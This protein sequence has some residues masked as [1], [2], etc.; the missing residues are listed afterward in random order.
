M[1]ERSLTSDSALPAAPA[2]HLRAFLIVL[3]L[4]ILHAWAVWGYTGIFWGEHGR[5]LH[6]VARFAAGEVP[7]RDFSYSNPPLA[8][9]LVGG[10]ARMT[11]ATYAGITAITTTLYLLT[12]V[13]YVLCVRR[14]VPD[15]VLPVTLPA[16]LF[17]VSYSFRHGVSLPAGTDSPA[18]P[19]GFLCILGAAWLLLEAVE[20]PSLARAAGYGLLLGLAALSRHEFWI[21]CLYLLLAGGAF[22]ARRRAPLRVQIA[23]PATFALIIV[24]GAMAAAAAAGWLDAARGFLNLDGA[25]TSLLRG[26][27]SI[28]R[29]VAE[30]AGAAAMALTAITALWLC[31]AVNDRT[32]SRW[33]GAMLLLFLTAAAMHLGTSVSIAAQL[34]ES[35]LPDLPTL[36]QDALWRELQRG[37]GTVSAALA[38]FDA[39]LQAHL[40]PVILPPIILVALLARWKQWHD[41]VLRGRVALLLGLCITARLRRGF[42]GADWYNVL[43]ELPAYAV[44][45]QL[46]CGPAR[47]KAARAVRAGLAVLIVIGIY[48]YVSLAV[49]PFTLQGVYPQMLT[50]N[51]MVR[52]PSGA[53]LAYQTADRLVQRA[54]PAARRPVFAFGASGGWNFFLLRRSPLPYLDGLPSPDRATRETATALIHAARAFL[55]D[56]AYA[57]RQVLAVPSLFDWEPPAEPNRFVRWDRVWFDGLIG[58]CAPVGDADSTAAIHVYDCDRPAPA[59]VP[60]PR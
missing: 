29:L 56:N 18:A 55:I 9:W 26:L 19:I 53:A 13:V 41:P 24:I 58:D 54:D 47:Q 16:L 7:Y 27:P 33:A 11:G 42:A 45:L 20:R 31:L 30:I 38:L 35:G 44:F 17:S 51:G 21:S 59:A 10:L 8:L 36:T 48:T 52:W 22:L 1:P 3:G 12:F 39:R 40:F 57:R 6:A 32:A 15:L 2:Q 50:R 37:Q 34:Q 43:L 46:A 60:L 5:W 49:G 25:I 4:A 14:L 23:G 28:E